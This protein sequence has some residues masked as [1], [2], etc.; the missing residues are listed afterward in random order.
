MIADTATSVQEHTN[1]KLNER[2]QNETNERIA[3]F[4]RNDHSEH[5]DSRLKEL[6]REWD[7]E[8]TLQTNFAVLSLVG[9]TLAPNVRNPWRW[10]AL[11]VP[12]FMVQHGLFGWCPP[13]PVL[14]RLGVRTSRE[15]GDERFALK[16]LRGDF[17][18]PAKSS[19]VDD[20]LQASKF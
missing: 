14:R 4:K 13:L 11:V 9:L 19:H 20:I 5:I 7:V 12:A 16:A 2:I 17:N 1:P 10:L 8:R 18:A 3:R 6:D 15:I